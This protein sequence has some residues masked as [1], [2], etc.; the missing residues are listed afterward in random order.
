MKLTAL[1][2][3]GKVLW[4]NFA[5]NPMTE[6]PKSVLMLKLVDKDG[7]PAAPPK[8]TKTAGDSRLSPNETRALTYEMP[9]KGVAL[10]RAE[11]RY[12]LLPPPMMKKLGDKLPPEGKKLYLVARSEAEVK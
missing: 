8:A 7:K 2:A 12:G 3:D 10:V 5:K 6:D 11:L 9:A 1:D 4:S